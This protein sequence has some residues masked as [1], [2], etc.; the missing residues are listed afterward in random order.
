MYYNLMFFFYLFGHKV[1]VMYEK[2]PLQPGFSHIFLV[3]WKYL[4][5]DLLHVKISMNTSPFI[6]AESFTNIKLCLLTFLMLFSYILFC[7]FLNI[8]IP[9]SFSFMS[10]KYIIAL[11]FIFNLYESF[12]FQMCLVSRISLDLKKNV[13]PFEKNLIHVNLL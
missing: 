3:L 9:A 13:C 8:F 4:L 7:L 12:Y 10:A 6:Y 5:Y 1:T 11:F 2:L